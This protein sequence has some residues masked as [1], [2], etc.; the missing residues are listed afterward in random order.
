MVAQVSHLLAFFRLAWVM[1]RRNR[2]AGTYSKMKA[3]PRVTWSTDQ[4]NGL[5]LS[6]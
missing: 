6:Y 5:I 1:T 2:E 4:R 3:C